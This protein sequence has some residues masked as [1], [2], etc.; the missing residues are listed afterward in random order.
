MGLSRRT[1]ERHGQRCTRS[2][3]WG[4][5]WKYTLTRPLP[6]RSLTSPSPS[7]WRPRSLATWSSRS[8]GE[9]V[10]HPLRARHL[11][12]LM[13]LLPACSEPRQYEFDKHCNALSADWA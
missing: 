13:R 7:V 1:L 3:T 6:T 4:I 12:V 9:E 8:W 2:S 10:D 5:A 11:Q